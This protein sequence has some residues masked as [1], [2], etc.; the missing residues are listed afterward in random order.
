M[1]APPPFSGYL[2]FATPVLRALLAT[3]GH[4]DL[5]IALLAG[6]V[7]GSLFSFVFAFC[8]Y[9]LVLRRVISNDFSV[10]IHAHVYFDL[11]FQSL[12]GVLQGVLALRSL[13]Y[14]LKCRSVSPVR[15]RR[16]SPIL[17]YLATAS[18]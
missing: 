18:E 15:Q 6:V 1:E 9:H 10:A 3:W 8:G 16:V 17:H 4:D 12:S 14:H 13:Q 2:I 5:A 11:S 7:G